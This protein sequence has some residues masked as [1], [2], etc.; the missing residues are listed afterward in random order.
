VNEF[1]DMLKLEENYLRNKRRVGVV[2]EIVIRVLEFFENQTSDWLAD[3]LF[4]IRNI[5]IPELLKVLP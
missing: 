2:Q 5:E 3:T 1:Y 4:R